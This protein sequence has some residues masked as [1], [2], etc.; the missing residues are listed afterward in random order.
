MRRPVVLVA[1][2]HAFGA[3]LGH[4]VEKLAVGRH[5][6][7]VGNLLEQHRLLLAVFVGDAHLRHGE[8]LGAGVEQRF[9]VENARLLAAE[10]Q[11]RH[12][13]R[14]ALGV[15]H[16]EL[17]RIAGHGVALQ[18]PGEVHIGSEALPRHPGN[19]ARLFARQIRRESRAGNGRTA[20]AVEAIHGMRGQRLLVAE[21]LCQF[22]LHRAVERQF[23]V[24][25]RCRDGG[26]A[27]GRSVLDCGTHG[28]A[29]RHQGRCRG[30]CRRGRGRGLALG[31][32]GIAGRG[33][34]CRLLGGF[35]VRLLDR[36]EHVAQHFEGDHFSR[37]E[38]AAIVLAVDDLDVGQRF[39]L[40]VLLGKRR[41]DL[42]AEH[43]GG[44]RIGEDDERHNCGNQ[45][46]FFHFGNLP[47]AGRSRGVG[48]HPVR[49]AAGRSARHECGLPDARAIMPQ[50]A[51][52]PAAA[53]TRLAFVRSFADH[54]P[55]GMP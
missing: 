38:H 7:V 29:Q 53:R 17:G 15:E 14:N 50:N 27:R 43:P 12:H 23:A 5:G 49:H 18:I 22:L 11:P 47:F 24:G 21:Q 30:G 4:H 48:L 41:L 40:L 51:S 2:L 32:F 37:G 44:K 54:L 33:L 45:A 13:G 39:D 1:D 36:A 6:D 9:V 55:T 34:L 10:F 52:P 42:L 31:G 35:L 16:L 3:H 28:K 8:A 26:H 20:A 46:G 25:D 19:R